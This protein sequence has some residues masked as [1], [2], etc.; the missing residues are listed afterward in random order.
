M[1]LYSIK[2]EDIGS[3]LNLGTEYKVIQFHIKHEYLK[4]PT[5][6]VICC[7]KITESEL[8]EYFVLTNNKDEVIF[9]GRC[10]FPIDSSRNIYI[11]EGIPID[12]ESKIKEIQKKRSVFEEKFLS[13]YPICICSRDLSIRSVFDKPKLIDRVLS[14]DSIYSYSIKE[15]KLPNFQFNLIFN[16]FKSNKTRVSASKLVFGDDGIECS[17]PHDL[18][19]SWSKHIQSSAIHES[20]KFSIQK[21]VFQ[22][23]GDSYTKSYKVGGNLEFNIS[24]ESRVKEI[25]E[26]NIKNSDSSEVVVLNL[27]IDVTDYIID[28]KKWQK[29]VQYRNGDVVVFLEEGYAI[30]AA[31]TVDHTAS[32]ENYSSR[33][34]WELAERQDFFEVQDF[35]LFS[36]I[37]KEVF[38]SISRYIN[39]YISL[40][41]PQKILEFKAPLEKWLDIDIG[42]KLNCI[43][44]ENAFDC[45]VT[46][47]SKFCKYGEEYIK[48]RASVAAVSPS[49]GILEAWRDAYG[50]DTVDFN[51]LKVMQKAEIIDFN[52]NQ[53]ADSCLQVQKQ[54]A[55]EIRLKVPDG[56]IFI[57]ERMIRLRGYIVELFNEDGLYE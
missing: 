30:F 36:R 54:A 16:S 22:K 56:A 20:S 53:L 42:V 6:E 26:L 49:E 35:F 2:K 43:I 41:Y 25:V 38:E 27:P 37:G 34:F 44:E 9:I 5:A 55:G 12:L 51:G 13:D 21:A 29:G 7:E 28:S 47:Y 52:S 10:K 24:C 50:P 17:N 40:N 46:S 14:E 19:S 39:L 15:N 23:S 33:D 1:K 45:V 8:S 11:F 3:F 48:I 31:C 18:I 32:E 4:P 57:S